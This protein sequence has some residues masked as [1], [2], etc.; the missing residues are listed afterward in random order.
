MNEDIEYIPNWLS[1]DSASRLFESLQEELAWHQGD[2]FIF[3]KW[4]KIPRLQAF[5][6]DPDVG[7]KYSGKY[8]K[9]ESWTPA[10]LELKRSWSSW[11]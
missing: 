3:G 11:I 8:L 10:L 4:H 1:S 5:H 7:Y 9:A 6:G 2:V